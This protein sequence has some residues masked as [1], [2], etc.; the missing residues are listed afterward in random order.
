MSK[1]Y[2]GDSDNQPVELMRANDTIIENYYTKPEIINQQTKHLFNLNGDAIPD[3]VFKILSNSAII[4][5]NQQ[6][7]GINP[8]IWKKAY[9][10]N[11]EY[12]C[13]IA[14]SETS[15]IVVT[16]ISNNPP[17][18]NYKI[19]KS[20][21]G[22]EWNQVKTLTIQST[23]PAQLQ[24]YNGVFVL[25]DST[26]HSCWYSIDDGDT[27][28]DGQTIDG[29][30][31]RGFLTATDTGFIRIISQYNDYPG[32]SS[33][34]YF[35]ED[36]I[37]WTL[38]TSS[39][40]YIRDHNLLQYLNGTL[41]LSKGTSISYQGYTKSHDLGKSWVV[42]DSGA[43]V[44]NVVYSPITDKYYGADVNGSGGYLS[45]LDHLE[46]SSVTTFQRITP[47]LAMASGQPNAYPYNLQL[48]YAFGYIFSYNIVSA[49]YIKYI[50]LQSTTL[51]V[52]TIDLT[53]IITVNNSGVVLLHQGS[54]I[55]KNKIFL[56]VGSNI[57]YNDNLIYKDDIQ[58]SNIMKTYST[59]LNSISKIVTGSYIGTGRTN[60][61]CVITFPKVPKIVYIAQKDI[62]NLNDGYITPIPYFWG[63]NTLQMSQY[64]GTNW[65]TATAY[66]SGNTLSFNAEYNDLN[67]SQ[68]T[69]NYYAL[70]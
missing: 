29:Y 44:T 45:K 68:F 35:S 36:G 48:F 56:I 23:I 28:L 52:K 46:V 34:V 10:F 25:C 19:Y 62:S 33:V 63:E 39:G 43:A 27:W 16:R 58:L 42:V 37:V 50:D 54:L 13:S 2:V 18:N 55:F 15:L 60:G 53:N 7:V 38:Q 5:N 3:D 49:N 31:E 12:I 11:D 64:A 20:T 66:V 17:S 6:V 21:N 67:D 70:Y 51:T 26:A 69:Y 24:F 9:T 41:I 65:R 61:T 40:P 30:N 14:N 32:F 57:I 59:S 8:E 47:E 1:F 22:L 4:K